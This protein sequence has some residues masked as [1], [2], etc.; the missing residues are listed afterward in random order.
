MFEG[1]DV[2]AVADG[3]EGA[4]GEAGGVFEAVE[5]ADAAG[6]GGEPD[7]VGEYALCDLGRLVGVG[8]DVATGGVLFAFEGEGGG[9]AG[10]DGLGGAVGCED[11]GESG[12]D[13]GG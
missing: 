13:V 5:G 9:V 6:L 7:E 3:G 4:E 12:A 11:G 1:V 8:D 10:G 2:D